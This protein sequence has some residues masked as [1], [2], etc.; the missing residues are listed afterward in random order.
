[1]LIG[2]ALGLFVLAALIAVGD[3]DELV[4]AVR[5]FDWWLTPIILSLVLGNYVLRFAKWHWYLNR[6]GIE[7]LAARDSALIFVAGFSMAITPGKVGEL[8][9]SYFVRIRANW[10]MTTTMPVIFAERLTDGAGLLVLGG[11]G[12]LGFRIGVP[13]FIVVA[14]GM[15]AAII[16]FGRER[17]M[18]GILERLRGTRFVRGRVDELTQLYLGTRKLLRPTPLLAMVSLSAMSWFLECVAFAL[19]LYGLGIE[20]TWF[21]VLAAT[22]VFAASAWIGGASLL[23]GGLGATEA[24]A[25]ALLLVVI[26]DPDLTRTIAASATLLLRVA[27]LWFGVIIGIIALVVVARWTQAERIYIGSNLQ[28]EGTETASQ[29]IEV[30]MERERP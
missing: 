1:M 10:P 25:A 24:S 13:A 19:I 5:E 11:V 30:E 18:L 15:G 2:L 3:R 9:K 12:L 23:P 29:K 20:L 27:T 6:V 14:V 22:F 4:R 7:N 21:L 8:L 26:D 17:L 28:Q 16:L